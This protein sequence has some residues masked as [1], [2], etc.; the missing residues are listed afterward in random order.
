LT[1]LYSHEKWTPSGVHFSFNNNFIMHDI[2]LLRSN[3]DSFVDSLNKRK[4]PQPFFDKDKF[5]ELEEQRKFL[6]KESEFLQAELNSTNKQIGIA[7]SKGLPCDNLIAE[8]TLKKE[9]ISEKTAKVKQLLLDI[10]NILLGIPN[11]PSDNTPIGNSESEN[12]VIK[13]HGDKPVFDFE[14]KDHIVLGKPYGLDFETGVKLSG[15][16]FC[17]MAGAIAT[18]HRAISQ[19]M[20]DTQVYDH[21]YTE[22]NV[23]YIVNSDVLV[24]TGQL[25]K[26]EE[27]M[28]HVTR[29]NDSSNKQYLI[30][31]AEISLTNSV[32]E[33]ILKPEQLP[34]KLTAHSAC[35]RSEAGSAGRDTTGLIRQHQ[36]EKVEMVQIVSAKDS[37]AA[38]EEM[39]A[40]AENIL[41]LLKL[42]YRVVE[43]CTGD[44]GFSAKKTYD[45]EVWI[46]SQN[47]YREISSVSNCGDFQARR[48]NTKV[49]V[50]K[51]N[52][53]VHT[54]NGSGLAVGR[55][56]V[57]I[58]ENYQ[59]ADGTI[60]IPDVLVPFMRRSIL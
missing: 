51:T 22:C 58:L 28:F 33:Q 50:D 9:G 34:I 42:P 37:E 23:P 32:R 41:K 24:G 40:H 3:I 15:S 47:T 25:P 4:S 17:Y 44:L 60:N 59:N 21:G 54:L 13:T 43:L 29:G 7:K 19:F 18:L 46:T 48:M 36:F 14:I 10:D 20:L 12:V 11:L 2:K 39:L 6:Q 45:L 1:K 35:F 57:A 27:D 26:F 5:I 56:L 49:K 38:L 30:S 31:T 53:F 8:V 52:E 16:R 55:T